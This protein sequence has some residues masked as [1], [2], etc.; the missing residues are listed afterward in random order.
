MRPAG[1]IVIVAVVAL[2]VASSAA[3]VVADKFVR[4]VKATSQAAPDGGDAPEQGLCDVGM[5]ILDQKPSGNAL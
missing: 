4:Q 5:N 2:L 1:I 3:D